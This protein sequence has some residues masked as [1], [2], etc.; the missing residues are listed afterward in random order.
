MNCFIWELNQYN[1]L[2]D[3]YVI[4]LYSSIHL[5]FLPIFPHVCLS[6]C[7]PVCLPAC[8]SVCLPV[9][10]SARLP[11]C[12]S[13]CLSICLSACLPV[14]LSAWLPVCL[15]ACRLLLFKSACQ[16]CHLFCLPSARLLAC[17]TNWLAG[18]LRT[19]LSV[20]NVYYTYTGQNARIKQ[21][22]ETI[23]KY[24]KTSV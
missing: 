20:Q 16:F 17:I 24:K 1:K 10:L 4:P 19:Y 8:L 6:A 22:S 12:L 14:C 9:C 13:A 7:L 2:I 15:S 21:I 18:C 11:V 23:L 5:P 3:K